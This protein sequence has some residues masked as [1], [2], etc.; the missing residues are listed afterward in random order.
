MPET[1]LETIND[2]DGLANFISE[3]QKELQTAILQREIIEDERYLL[4]GEI[5]EF[6]RMIQD[7]KIKKIEMDRALNKSKVNC[8]TLALTIKRATSRFWQLKN[9]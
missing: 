1:S 6:Q 9:P 5:L 2:I 4:S 7:K 8:M 3:A